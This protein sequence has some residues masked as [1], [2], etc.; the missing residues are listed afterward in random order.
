[1]SHFA[2]LNLPTF[3]DPRGVL[4]V[5]EGALPFPV[6]RTYWIYGS[7][8]QTRGGHRRTAFGTFPLHNFAARILKHFAARF[9]RGN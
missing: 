8:G 6:V 3:K 9:G 1:M 4:T 5:M 2:L 7:D